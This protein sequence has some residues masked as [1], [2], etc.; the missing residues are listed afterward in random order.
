MK[1]EDYIEHLFVASTH[2]YILFFTSVGKVYRLKVHELPLG[3]RQ[4]K[5]RAIVNLLP[6]RQDELVRAVI[7]H[8]R[9]QGG[10]SSSLFATKRGI[11]KKTEFEAYNTPLKADGIIAIGLRDDNELVGVRLSN[12][13]NDVLMVSRLG[14]GDPLPTSD[15]RSMGR[16]A[17]GVQ[18][19]AAPREGRGDRGRH[20]RTTT[21]ICSS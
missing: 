3:S 13:T 12:G 15:V 10:R 8:A 14:P 16:P 11:V 1:D 2:D 21:P 20:R 18:G 17:S 4:S 19:D 6:F 7:A 5:G 9:L